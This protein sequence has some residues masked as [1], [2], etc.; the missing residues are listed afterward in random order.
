MEDFKSELNKILEWELTERHKLEE[1]AVKK[2]GEGYDGV[3]PEKYKEL[4]D[5]SYRKV[6]ELKT[7]YGIT[8]QD[9][10]VHRQQNSIRETSH[11]LAIG[12]FGSSGK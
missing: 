1:E 10:M 4:K 6:A 8:V 3:P 9:N 11:K 12:D 5:K 7:K 2:Y